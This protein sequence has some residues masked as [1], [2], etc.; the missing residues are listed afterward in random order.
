MTRNLKKKKKKNTRKHKT[1]GISLNTS[2]HARMHA[3]CQSARSPE[4][5]EWVG[6][7]TPN[8]CH[9][10]GGKVR[11]KSNEPPQ[12]TSGTDRS[13]ADFNYWPL[14]LNSATKPRTREKQLIDGSITWRIWPCRAAGG[15]RR[16]ARLRASRA[17]CSSSYSAC[18]L[19]SGI[20]PAS[21]S[22]SLHAKDTTP[23]CL[24]PDF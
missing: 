4:W 1:L 18:S 15:P 2:V 12:K 21:A 3:A 23:P 6:V 19:P 8:R 17:G 16:W 5:A 13:C 24:S 20:K 11:K 7:G 9:N 14:T 22:A 10:Q